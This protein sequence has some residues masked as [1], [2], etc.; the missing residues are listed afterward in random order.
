M[1]GVIIEP[2][3]CKF[4]VAEPKKKAY[5]VFNENYDSMNDFEEM[6]NAGIFQSIKRYLDV[7][8]SFEVTSHG[9]LSLTCVP[10]L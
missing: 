5:T 8:R 3:F 10:E 4:A 6:R 9:S 2:L 1:V 7:K